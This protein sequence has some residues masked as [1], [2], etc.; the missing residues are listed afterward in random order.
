MTEPEK[1]H[2]PSMASSVGVH[3]EHLQARE[4]QNNVS[5]LSLFL[6]VISVA[7]GFV[8]PILIIALQS[9]VIVQIANELGD[10]NNLSWPLSAFSVAGAVTFSIAGNLSDVFGRRMVILTGNTM[11][12]VGGIVGATAHSV[13]RLVVS[14]SIVGAAAGLIFVGYA[15]ISEILPNK[16][17]GAGIGL[18]E[19]LI[20]VPWSLVATLIATSI[21]SNTALS[22]RWFYIFGVIYAT[23]SLVGTAAFYFPPLR[24]RQD[25]EKTRWQQ[26]KEIDFFGCLLFGGGCCSIL[27][28]IT[29][30]G[31]QHPWNSAAVI[32]PLVVGFCS[33]ACTFAYDAFV[34]A[35]PLIPFQL[36]REVRK[37]V[38]CLVVAFVAGFIYYSMSA[39]LP[40]A[41]LFIF[42][43]DS[44][45]IGITQIPN[46]IGQLLFGS[47]ASAAIGPIGHLR[48][49]FIF[50]TTL[51]VVAVV[52]MAATIPHHKAAF[53]TLQAFGVG[54]FPTVTALTIVIAS[55]NVPLPYLG[56]AIGLIGTFRSAGGSF[57]NAILQTILHSVVNEKLAPAIIEASAKLGFDP[58]HAGELIGATVQNALG[59]PFAFSNVTG[60]TPEIEHAASEALKSAYAYAYQRVFYAIIPFGVIAIICA[61]LVHDPSQH[62]TNHT[63]VRME[64]EGFLGHGKKSSAQPGER[65]NNLDNE[66]NDV[67]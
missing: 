21:Y 67:V 63:D 13:M 12:I 19:F 7:T 10:T 25:F 35:S 41:T 66:A 61:V 38:L 51:M 17:R 44:T 4:P 42:T 53:M 39:L 49:Q 30:A 26:F 29:W 46:G 2:E 1:Q 34:P 36:I 16:W 52:C 58:E 50:W 8:G 62:L 22:W 14:D 3:V 27:V 55:F 5:T 9:S 6:A 28:A 64:K 47:V 54:P 45:Q 33:V 57:G 48:I 11:M 37:Y 65:T 60:I 18:T 40:Q 56:V 31:S 15:S 23:F 24:P 20:T 43:S 32:A 59:V